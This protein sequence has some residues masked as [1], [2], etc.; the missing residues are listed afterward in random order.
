MIQKWIDNDG[1]FLSVLNMQ[2]GILVNSDAAEKL[3]KMCDPKEC[4]IKI[5][6][7]EYRITAS[8]FENIMGIKPG[9]ESLDLQKV[10]AGDLF[11]KFGTFQNRDKPYVCCERVL[12][13]LKEGNEADAKIA[14]NL[15]ALLRVLVP[16]RRDR[17][18]SKYLN[19][20]DTCH[21]NKDW[22]GH[23]LEQMFNDIDAY[24]KSKAGRHLKLFCMKKVS[25]DLVQLQSVTEA[26]VKK[27][28]NE[29]IKEGAS[30]ETEVL[31]SVHDRLAKMLKGMTE[32]AM[33]VLR[34]MNDDGG[35]NYKM[36]TY[37][38]HMQKVMEDYHSTFIQNSS[39]H[40]KSEGS[41]SANRHPKTGRSGR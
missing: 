12:K 40:Q 14:Y 35:A 36:E 20:I 24:Q 32:E 29:H 31:D 28:V 23:F 10:K 25:S 22:A 21:E 1:P 11:D 18:P 27:F 30:L 41:D 3:M 26:M 6:G 5:N 9:T 33:E 34:T 16:N 38:L 8:D 2:K 19:M 17:F 37:G 4:T 7:A 15:L 39:F 13:C